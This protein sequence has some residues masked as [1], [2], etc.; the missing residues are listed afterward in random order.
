M[1]DARDLTT[2]WRLTCT[3]LSVRRGGRPVIQDVS[4]EIHHGEC[5]SLVG[6]NGSGKTTLLLAMLGLLPPTGGTVRLDHRDIHDI[7]ARLRGRFSAYVPQVVTNVPAFT[8]SDVV[9]GGRHPHVSP[10]GPLSEEDRAIV[11]RA[12]DVCG[13]AHLAGRPIHE[14]SG[15]ERQKAFIAAAIAQDPR[16][17]FLDEPNTALDPAVQLDLL[18]ILRSWTATGRSILLIS[19]DLQLP[20]ALGGRVVALREGRVAADG[21]AADVLTPERLSAIYGAQFGTATT[22]GGHT[23][24][25]PQWW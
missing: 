23:I 3:N 19:H 11:Q 24:V 21:N 1:S 2:D 15:G 22:P 16:V 7:P 5:V 6:P 9:A 25:L 4:L 10:I 8:V 18:R 20:A 13:L 17:M 14:V 12:L